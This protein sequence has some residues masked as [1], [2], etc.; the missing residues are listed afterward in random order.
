MTKPRR[1]VLADGEAGVVAVAELVWGSD[2][3]LHRRVLRSRR[4]GAGRR[5]LRRTCTEAGHRSRRAATGI[6]CRGRSR[7]MGDRR[8]GGRV[9]GLPGRGRPRS[10]FVLGRPRPD[11]LFAGDGPED[12]DAV[13]FHHGG[14]FAET[15]PGVGPQAKFSA[16]EAGPSPSVHVVRQGATSSSVFLASKA[17]SIDRWRTQVY[18]GISEGAHTPLKIYTITLHWRNQWRN[19]LP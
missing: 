10:V 2:H 3:R 18:T 7:G 6:R 8:G 19:P 11:H 14:C 12:E 5:S 9:R 13:A 16:Q 17:F 15:S 4:P 1:A